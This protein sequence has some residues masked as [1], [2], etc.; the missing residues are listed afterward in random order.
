MKKTFWGYDV[1]AVDEELE[2]LEMQNYKLSQKVKRLENER[3]DV[4][5]RMEEMADELKNAQAGTR[6]DPKAKADLAALRA[7]LEAAKAEAAQA[8]AQV[9]QLQAEQAE[10][11]SKDPDAVKS[12]TRERMEQL[13]DT[14]AQGWAKS[15]DM[16]KRL[17][18]EIAVSRERAREAFIVSADEILKNFD[19]IGNAVSEVAASVNAY[20]DKQSMLMTE[21]DD[22]FAMLDDKDES[23]DSS[24]EDI[25]EEDLPIILKEIKAR[26]AALRKS[27]AQQY[28]A[29]HANDRVT[30]N[31]IL[32]MTRERDVSDKKSV[33]VKKRPSEKRNAGGPIDVSL[34]VEAKDFL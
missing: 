10:L 5:I 33:P 26:I 20:E 12:M 14:Y 8:K 31:G 9:E 34:S 1:K 15:N 22:I 23:D 13:L 16:L 29:A 6:G 2:K 3:N 28:A 4:N 19:G 17:L 7:E 24:I 27:E 18:E 32:P 30:G 11:K 21:F 25:P